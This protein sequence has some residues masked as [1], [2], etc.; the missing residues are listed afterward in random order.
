MAATCAVV[1]ARCVADAAMLLQHVLLSGQ[2]W[3]QIADVASIGMPLNI[4]LSKDNQISTAHDL[5][6]DS[7]PMFA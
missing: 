3:Q 5:A 2:G 7:S 1:F 4:E 6:Y